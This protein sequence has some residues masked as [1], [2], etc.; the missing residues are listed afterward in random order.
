[1]EKTA[2]ASAVNIEPGVLL[3][4]L[5][6]TVEEIESQKDFLARHTRLKVINSE[7]GPALGS[8]NEFNL[9]IRIIWEN[10]VLGRDNYVHLLKALLKRFKIK[11]LC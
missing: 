6:G 9:A 3:F 1:M 5:L 7:A 10:Q 8:I 4:P 2:Q 11:D